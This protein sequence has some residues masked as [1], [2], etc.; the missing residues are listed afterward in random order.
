[1]IRRVNYSAWSR[2]AFCLWLIVGAGA[3]AA[4]RP[5]DPT[6]PRANEPPYPVLMV[7]DADRRET[8]LGEWT[9]LVRD[10]GIMNA[11]APELQPVTATLR[12]IPALSTPLYLPK[13]GEGT[14]MTEE[15]TRESLRRFIVYAHD[16]IGA[17]PRQLSLVLRTDLADGT[18]KA[19]Y[20]QRPFR[21]AIRGGY[22]VL[23]ITF[24][25]DRRI[26]QVTSTC[27]PEADQ[28]QRAGAGVRPV[29][30]A[31]Q[32]AQRISGQTVTYTDA[33][34]NSQTL[35]VNSSDE[36]TAR[37]LVVYPRPRA[38]DPSVLEF[39][40]AWEVRISPANERAVYLI[41]L[42]AVTGEI[43]AAVQFNTEGIST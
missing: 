37:E 17:E 29:V 14:P 1:M 41:Y 32:V 36:I 24:T 18:K 8:A 43:I 10:Q 25:P 4:S 39:H 23:E 21:Y 15:E 38:N 11:P 31:D 26:L 34:R 3:C 19:Q 6:G 2:I 40:L 16:L 7:E 35:T 27:I 22:G 42:D 5:V 9:T 30:T 12:S 33:A 20:R 28:L 13:V